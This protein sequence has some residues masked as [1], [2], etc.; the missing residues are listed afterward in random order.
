MSFPQF[1]EPFRLEIDANDKGMG[2]VLSQDIDNLNKVVAYASKV[3]N[4]SVYSDP[5]YSSKRIEFKA[6]IWAICDK[7]RYFAYSNKRRSNI[8]TEER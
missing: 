6:L 8:G 1:D 3:T 4:A 7:F 2:A 5:E